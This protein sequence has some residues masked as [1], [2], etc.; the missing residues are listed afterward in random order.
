MAFVAFMRQ[1]SQKQQQQNHGP[2]N[3]KNEHIS[4]LPVPDNLGC[5]ILKLHTCHNYLYSAFIDTSS[6]TNKQT[7][8]NWKS[9]L[10]EK[11]FLKTQSAA[12]GCDETMLV[13]AIFANVFLCA[14]QSLSISAPDIAELS[15][16]YSEVYYH[17]AYRMFTNNAFPAS[18]PAH[19][20]EPIMEQ[21]SILAKTSVLLTHYQCATLSEE[22]AFLTFKI[23]LT[24][25]ERLGLHKLSTH[26]TSQQ[27]FTQFYNAE[28]DDARRLWITADKVNAEEYDRLCNLWKVIRGW[29]VWFAVYLDRPPMVDDMPTDIPKL[30]PPSKRIEPRDWA[31]QVVDVY[32][33][34]MKTMFRSPSSSSCAQLKVSTKDSHPIEAVRNRSRA[35][36]PT[37]TFVHFNFMT[38]RFFS[39]YIAAYHSIYLCK[40]EEQ[41]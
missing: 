26:I 37:D 8:S 12:S 9:K 21:L 41:T 15:R 2:S 35:R 24:F 31:M 32:I 28:V 39:R 20:A 17:Q 13:Y 7:A 3:N 38:L 18:H 1:W 34:S 36:S 25:A 29:D 23:G 6:A 27:H 4:K 11:P 30:L 33:D 40:Y 14:S 5:E 10:S 22:Q 19:P 16:Q